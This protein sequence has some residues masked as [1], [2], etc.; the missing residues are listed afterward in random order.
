VFP[1]DTSIFTGKISEERMEKEHPLEY[2]RLI[3]KE[4][5]PSTHGERRIRTS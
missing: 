3:E 2:E 4:I 5:E 1:F